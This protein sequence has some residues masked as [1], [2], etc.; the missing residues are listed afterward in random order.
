LNQLKIDSRDS[1]DFP[2]TNQHATKI[3]MYEK[4]KRNH[5]MKIRIEESLDY[6]CKSKIRHKREY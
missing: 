5:W 3:L 1:N 6:I 4:G 2:E